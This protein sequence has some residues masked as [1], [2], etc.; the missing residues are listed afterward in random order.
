MR[1]QPLRH[2]RDDAYIVMP[3]III[4]EGAMISLVATPSKVLQWDERKSSLVHFS[5]EV[6]LI[7]VYFRGSY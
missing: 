5:H 6:C 3:S 2:E 4:E 7:S 1:V